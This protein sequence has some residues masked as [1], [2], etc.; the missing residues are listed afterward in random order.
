MK[1]P[2][3]L[4]SHAVIMDYVM[5]CGQAVRPID[6]SIAL[7]HISL[8]AAE[9]GLGTCWIGSFETEKVKELLAIPSDVSIIELMALGYPAESGKQNTRVA[10]KKF[11]V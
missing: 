5:K 6:V 4:L 10:L 11:C 9:L 7:E 8:Q 3:Q 2:G 1:K